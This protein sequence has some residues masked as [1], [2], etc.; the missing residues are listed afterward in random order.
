MS[1]RTSAWLLPQKEHI[2]RLEA[3]AMLP[4]CREQFLF[5]DFRGNAASA[6][7]AAVERLRSPSSNFASLRD[8]TTSST[9][10]YS[11]ASAAVM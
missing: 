5:L 8:L 2:V 9:S 7:V 3:R 4:P 1:L 6:A 10:P 11:F